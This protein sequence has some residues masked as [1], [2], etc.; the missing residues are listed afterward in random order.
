MQEEIPVSTGQ[1]G[2]LVASRPGWSRT[3]SRIA[4]VHI[5]YLVLGEGQQGQ[6]AGSAPSNAAQQYL[7]MPGQKGCRQCYCCNWGS[8]CLATVS[9]QQ[10][11][12][13]RHLN[14]L[15]GCNREHH[16]QHLHKAA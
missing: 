5:N 10:H 6:G 3:T 7:K 13:T 8:S 12:Q 9:C 2:E 4:D 16:P 1:P 11:L 14:S 15:G